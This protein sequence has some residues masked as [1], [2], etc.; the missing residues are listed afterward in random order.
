LPLLLHSHRRPF[1]HST[2]RPLLNSAQLS[3][4]QLSS[5]SYTDDTCCSRPLLSLASSTASSVS[6]F[7]HGLFGRQSAKSDSVQVNTQE[8]PSLQREAEERRG[9]V[10]RYSSPTVQLHLGRRI[11]HKSRFWRLFLRQSQSQSR[12]SSAVVVVH[13]DLLSTLN[14]IR[15]EPAQR[16]RVT[17]RS[18]VAFGCNSV[19]LLLTM[20][21]AT[22]FAITHVF[23]SPRHYPNYP[24]HPIS[25]HSSSP[26]SSASSLSSSSGE[27]ETEAPPIEPFN[28]VKSFNRSVSAIK[29]QIL[30]TAK[31]NDSKSITEMMAVLDSVSSQL[32]QFTKLH[33]Q[34]E[35]ANEIPVSNSQ[36]YDKFQLSLTA[37]TALLMSVLVSI[38]IL[39]ACF[40]LWY[41]G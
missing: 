25:A 28:S 11:V 22:Q 19:L 26:M 2:V 32:D 36:M 8:T 23:A 29:S 27:I 24:L 41:F 12:S 4:A 15:T 16:T 20:A 31:H 21:I 5:S 30:K 10:Q 3:L 13:L 38:L 40:V 37:S 6:F 33:K 35:E 9:E 39:V 7:I 18:Q 17:M 14:H 1:H 34:A